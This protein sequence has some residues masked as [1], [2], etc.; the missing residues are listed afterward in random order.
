ME[1][2]KWKRSIEGLNAAQDWSK[3]LV[4]IETGMITVLWVFARLTARS[5]QLSGCLK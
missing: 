5:R 2:E 1:P 3:W 4:T